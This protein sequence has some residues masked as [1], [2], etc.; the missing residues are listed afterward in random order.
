[1]AASIDTSC[2][3]REDF[4]EVELRGGESSLGRAIAGQRMLGRVAI[5]GVHGAQGDL[6][7]VLIAQVMI[8]DVTEA[9]AIRAVQRAGLRLRHNG[10]SF[11]CNSTSNDLES[12]ENSDSNRDRMEGDRINNHARSSFRGL[13]VLERDQRGERVVTV[14]KAKQRSTRQDWIRCT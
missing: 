6:V 7:G 11:R 3:E 14:I 4:V 8:E 12:R 2:E 5:D 10:R 9:G 13:V 1:M